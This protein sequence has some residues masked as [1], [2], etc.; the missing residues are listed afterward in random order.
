MNFIKRFAALSG[1]LIMAALVITTIVLGIMGSSHFIGV[2][3]ITLTFPIMLWGYLF[4]YHLVG[5]NKTNN[6]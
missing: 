2:L 5:K 4:I 6:N 3:I 1:V